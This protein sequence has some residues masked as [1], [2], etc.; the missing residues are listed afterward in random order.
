MIKTEIELTEELR[1]RI[2]SQIVTQE[3]AVTYWREV[4]KKAK[5]DSQE[6]VDALQSVVINQQMISKDKHYLKIIDDRLE[7]LNG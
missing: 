7:K 5:K 4:S 3:T 2:A 1:N 6:R